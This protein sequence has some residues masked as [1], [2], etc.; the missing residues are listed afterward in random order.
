MEIEDY[1]KENKIIF[2][3]D[4]SNLKDDYTRNR[5]RHF[6]MPVLKTIDPDFRKGMAKTLDNMAKTEAFIR[7][8]IYKLRTRYFKS[9]GHDLKLPFKALASDESSEFLL[10]ELL[11]PFD[12]N[13]VTVRNIISAIRS[14]SNSGKI[15]F[16]SGYELI[17]DRQELVIRSK[18]PEETEK[19]F[20]LPHDTVKIEAPLKMQ[21]SRTNLDT[22]F[23]LDKDKNV[24][25]IDFAKLKFPLKIRRHKKGDYFYPL[26]MTGK[27]LVSDYFTDLKFSLFEK[28]DTWLLESDN[29]I[30]WLIGHR[31]DDRFKIT[32]L[33]KQ[34]FICRLI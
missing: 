18:N 20:L 22:A 32:P 15:F 2:R 21:F 28:R 13:A 29:N 19:I 24:A 34:A 26:G 4:S 16:S 6:L 11:K 23:S 14:K 25:Q 5:I 3:E 10:Y 17:V 12:F 31:L 1:A 30:V 9:D 7:A 33:T 27:K 8:E